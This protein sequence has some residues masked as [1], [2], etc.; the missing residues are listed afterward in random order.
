MSEQFDGESPLSS[1]GAAMSVP[2]AAARGQRRQYTRNRTLCA[3]GPVLLMQEPPFPILPQA[4]PG[5]SGCERR[6]VDNVRE[7]RLV[8]I[9][10]HA[11]A[12]AFAK[13]SIPS[14]MASP[15]IRSS[16]ST[17]SPSSPTGCRPSLS[18]AS[19]ASSRS[20]HGGVRRRWRG[21]ALADHPRTSSTTASG[22]RCATSTRRRSTPSSSTNA[23]TRWRPSWRD[24]E[25]G[26]VD[27]AGYL[28]ISSPAATT[29]M[30]FDVEHS[31]LLQVG[32]EERPRRRLRG[33]S[34]PP[35]ARAQPLP[36]R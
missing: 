28:F 13:R 1:F 34:Q 14:S 5:W 17:P 35:A 16:R 31:F 2:D 25:G 18:G 8:D 21:P 4:Y 20:Q 36:R 22:S 19:R 27:R 9:D 7:S 24:R 33:R 3:Q 10:R 12:E 26:M 30:H 11:F 15:N 23:S 29:P 32:D 6:I